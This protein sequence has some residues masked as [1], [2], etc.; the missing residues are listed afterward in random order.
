M[1]VAWV[2]LT[3]GL[4]WTAQGEGEDSGNKNVT[5]ANNDTAQASGTAS[6]TTTSSPTSTQNNNASDTTAKPTSAASSAITTMKPTDG[7]AMIQTSVA[8]SQALTTAGQ[9]TIL[10]ASTTVALDTTKP[11]TTVT[12]SVK[13][14]TDAPT[15]TTAVNKQETTHAGGGILLSTTQERPGTQTPH[16]PNTTTN[17]NTNIN[18]STNINTNTTTN[19]NTNTS[20]NSPSTGTSISTTSPSTSIS[21]TTK[22]ETGD[23]VVP[24]PGHVS[25]TPESTTPAQPTT[26]VTIGTTAPTTTT[27]PPTTTKTLPPST[28][29]PVTFNLVINKDDPSDNPTLYKLCAKYLEM[30]IRGNCSISGKTLH[31]G[32]TDFNTVII[33]GQVNISVV[34][35]H[36]EELVKKPDEIKDASEQSD[37]TT[38]I[39]ILA[40]CGAV[41]LIIICLAIYTY[42]H[43][44]NY[45]KNQQHLTEE[46]Q[47]V[48]NGYHDNPTLEVMEVQPE[49]AMEKRPNGE[50]NDSWI[51][52][53]DNL[54]KDGLADEE[55]THL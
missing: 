46:L 28:A 49:T 15:I 36:Y 48:E 22:N 55:D 7:K 42:R 5:Q 17:I 27:V 24:V 26:T 47:T 4:L 23:S 19:I 31:D 34:K 18:T 54:L 20:T 43:G 14:P 53:M 39:A 35:S 11:L 16:N 9:T 12:P 44:K 21:T 51:V 10:S 40:S 1:R 3:L 32:S 52:P 41:A 2:I 30:V 13:S 37:Y 29:A 33:H 38:L 6:N 25:S 8:P 45:R 50:F